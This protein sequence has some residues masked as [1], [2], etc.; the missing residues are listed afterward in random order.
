MYNDSAVLFGIHPCKQLTYLHSP[1]WRKNSLILLPQSEVIAKD[2]QLN[3]DSRVYFIDQYQELSEIYKIQ[4]NNQLPIQRV[5]G[6]IEKVNLIRDV[7]CI[8]ERRS[9][10]SEMHLNVDY[11]YEWHMSRMAEDER[12]ITGTYGDLFMLLQE[13][14]GFTFNLTLDVWGNINGNGT[15]TGI[16]GRLHRGESN[17]SISQFSYNTE[18][19]LVIDFSKPISYA[20]KR[21][22]TKKPKDE[23]NWAAYTSVFTNEFWGVILTTTIVLSLSLLYILKN[24]KCSIEESVLPFKFTF[25]ALSGR[26]I[27][28]INSTLSGRIL[29][30]FILAWGF[31]ICSAYNAILTSELAVSKITPLQSLDDLLNSD[32]YSLLLRETGATPDFFRSANKNEIRKMFV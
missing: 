31:L 15:Y 26:E 8:W 7:K 32:K 2:L 24:Q 16:I 6:S 10:L 14:L 13:K 1:F 9:N 11:A 21:I 30:V 23:L 18:R 5:I 12:K 29:I 27:N 22:V 3:I 20:P 25:T 19:G 17:W 4:H 28:P